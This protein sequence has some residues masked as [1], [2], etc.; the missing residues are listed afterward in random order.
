MNWVGLY[1]L[2]E[3]ETKRFIS[4]WAQTVL[5]P[6]FSI[7]IFL[8]VFY[9]I[10][11]ESDNISNR[12]KLLFIAPGAITMAVIQNAFANTS[13]SILISK[14]QGNIVDT[15][16]PPLTSF[17]LLLGLSLG[18]MLRGLI[19]GALSALLIFPLIGLNCS[20]IY[21]VLFY[22]FLA[23]VELSL[24]G[25]LAGIFCEKFDHLNAITNFLITP[26]AFLSGTFY[27]ISVLPKELETIC[28]FN[29]FFWLIDGARFG[30]INFSDMKTFYGIVYT[31]VFIF[32]LFT[33]NW[34]LL[35][36][37]VKLKN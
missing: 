10:F 7:G 12:E 13:F 35:F 4:V 11:I 1:T 15:L 26:L 34:L 30:A 18:G 16:V 2:V 28:Y 23:S 9:L 20:N 31:G 36:R 5:A 37:G 14:I 29:P 19:I 32:L 8:I 33:I 17:E 21:L 27:S 22:F 6:I 24:L 25:I 3:R